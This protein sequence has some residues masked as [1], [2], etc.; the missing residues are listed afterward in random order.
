MAGDGAIGQ[1][2]AA[3]LIEQQ[4]QDGAHMLDML[5]RRFGLN[6]RRIM[7]WLQVRTN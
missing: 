1:A 5:E 6:R 3:L 7:L 4:W 2:D